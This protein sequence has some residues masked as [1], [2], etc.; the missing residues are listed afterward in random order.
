MTHTKKVSVP[1]P[2]EPNDIY[3][4][5]WFILIPRGLAVAPLNPGIV[6]DGCKAPVGI[7]PPLVIEVVNH[8]NAGLELLQDI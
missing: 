7:W 6:D 8:G 1:L 5:A 2:P 3:L 4:I